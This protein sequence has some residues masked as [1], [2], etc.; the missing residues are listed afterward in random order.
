MPFLSIFIATFNSYQVFYDTSVC[1]W[2]PQLARLNIDPL[3]CDGGTIYARD[4]IAEVRLRMKGSQ[5]LLFQNRLKNPSKPK[6]DLS[7]F[8][9]H[10]RANDDALFRMK[11]P[12][13]GQ[14]W[15]KAQFKNTSPRIKL[16][17]D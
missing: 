11:L 8:I 9:R 10:Y 13:K 6:E 15:R 17:D 5:Q 1:R 16:L 4:G 12:H 2:C 3:D 14:N 7:S